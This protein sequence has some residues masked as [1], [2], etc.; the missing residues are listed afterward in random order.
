[1]KH[2]IKIKSFENKI[3]FHVI[4]LKIDVMKMEYL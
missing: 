4:F 2:V 1:M 3:I